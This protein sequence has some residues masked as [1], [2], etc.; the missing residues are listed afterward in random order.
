MGS[1]TN[2]KRPQLAPSTIAKDFD[3]VSIYIDRFPDLTLDG[4]VAVRDYLN[5][6]TTPN[7]TKR[8]LTQLGACCKWAMKSKLIAVN[9]FLGMAADIKLPKGRGEDVDIN[10]FSP[11]ERDLIIE[12]FKTTNSEYASLVEF[13]FRTGCRP[14]EAIAGY[15]STQISIF[16]V[17]IRSFPI[18]STAG[19]LFIVPQR[20]RLPPVGSANEINGSIWVKSGHSSGTGLLRAI[21]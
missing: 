8:V 7:T 1:Y 16:I 20:W 6:K 19:I 18:V 10:P 21:L 9:P 12:H 11:E 4:A 17:S 14:S 2:Y 5:L 3:R 15:P 13:M